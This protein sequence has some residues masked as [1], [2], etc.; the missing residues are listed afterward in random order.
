MRWS[1]RL[2]N[3]V[4]AKDMMLAMIGRFGMNG[5]QYQAVEYCGEA[6]QA[7][8]M[9]ERMTLCNMSAE[10]GAQTG[11]VAPDDVTREWLA[12][13]GARGVETVPWHSDE[14]AAGVRH[15]FDASTLAPQ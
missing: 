1:G 12:R 4:A 9:A 3:G 7:L 8:P 2:A 14:D 10:L 5:G 15:A 11:L 13:H 6:V